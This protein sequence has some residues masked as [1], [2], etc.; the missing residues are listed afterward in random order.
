MPFITDHIFI[1]YNYACQRAHPFP[2][3]DADIQCTGLFKG[4]C[5]I[6]FQKGVEM[7][8]P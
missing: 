4:F 1:A 6:Y 3:T 2:V 5:F 8:G 7:P